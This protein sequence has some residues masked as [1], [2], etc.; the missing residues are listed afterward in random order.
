MLEINKKY[1]SSI[2]LLTNNPIKIVTIIVYISRYIK[3]YLDRQHCA[4]IYHKL[5]ILKKMFIS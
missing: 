4:L 2:C 5:K 1:I 3:I